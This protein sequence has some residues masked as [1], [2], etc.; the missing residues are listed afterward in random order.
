MDLSIYRCMLT[1]Y[2]PGV[3]DRGWSEESQ[4]GG[5]GNTKAILPTSTHQ[6]Q[7]L[8]RSQTPSLNEALALISAFKN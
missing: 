7:E 5:K 1:R 6:I 2:Q 3:N 8:L 4:K